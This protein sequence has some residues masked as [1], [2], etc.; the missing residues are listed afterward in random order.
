MSDQ[1]FTSMRRAMVESQLRTNDI[2]DPAIIRA[3]LSIPRE[4]YVPAERRD[5]AYIDR[6]VPL[7]EGRALNPPLA[8]ARLLIAASISSG[9][10]VLLI[11]AATGYS[12]ALISALGARVT[13]VESDPALAARARELLAGRAQTTVIEGPLEAGFADN[14]PYD[15]LFVDGAV[16]VMPDSLVEQLKVRGRAV[17]ARAEQGVTRLCMGVRSAGGFGSSAFADSETVILPGFARP[18]DFAF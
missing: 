3:I 10:K 8:T 17:F 18:R 7:C 5:T 9:Q 16:E 11:G 13:A 12:A 15:I 4:D 6:P 2:N 1:S 14:A